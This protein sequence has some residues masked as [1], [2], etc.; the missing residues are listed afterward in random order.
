MTQGAPAGDTKRDS[1]RGVVD[2]AAYAGANL[3]AGL[4]LLRAIGVEAYGVYALVISVIAIGHGLLASLVLEPLT[5]FGAM[6]DGGIDAEGIVGVLA[7]WAVVVAV[8]ALGVLAVVRGGAPVAVAAAAVAALAGQFS[9][10]LYRRFSY[11]RGRSEAALL[12]S[13]IYMSVVLGGAGF[14]FARGQLTIPATLAVLGLGGVPAG[15]YLARLRG[16]YARRLS[17]RGLAG[18]L[19]Y[20]RWS[21]AAGLASIPATQ[22]A[23]WIGA[24]AGAWEALGLLKLFEQLTYPAA[25]VFMGV[26]QVRLPGLV[27]IHEGGSRAETLASARRTLAGFL[28]LGAVYVVVLNAAAPGFV[29]YLVPE[30]GAGAWPWPLLAFSSVVL[31]RA[32]ANTINIAAKAMRVPRAVFAGYVAMAVGVVMIAS[33]SVV[34]GL[35]ALIGAVIVGWVL[36]CGAAAIVVVRAV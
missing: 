22:G 19:A 36:F 24:A 17:E 9:I 10:V 29:P 5:V 21:V 33:A 25:Q 28:G 26:S 32:G 23:Y 8:L 18:V 6:R 16:L 31:V 13:L 3:V 11:V 30:A 15:A 20:T 7:R 4:L 2:Q 35:P 27:R 1:L 34:V 14:M 12:G